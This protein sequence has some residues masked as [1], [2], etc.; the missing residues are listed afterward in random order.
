MTGTTSQIEWAELIKPRVK[1]EFDRV[2]K[3]FQTVAGGQ[4]GRAQIDTRAVI[5]I[6]EEKRKEVLAKDK[7]G[8]FIH[9]WQE[10]TDQVRRIISA[11]PRYEAIRARRKARHSHA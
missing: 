10:L 9:D 11:D 3:A 5:A 8:Y 4:S 6:L 2:A 7:A 1:A